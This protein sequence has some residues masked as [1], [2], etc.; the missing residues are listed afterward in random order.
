MG[1]H[2]MI[3]SRK[4]VL[5]GC[6]VLMSVFISCLK[7]SA[8]KAEG[9][10]SSVREEN[11]IGADSA[12]VVDIRAMDY[13]FGMPEEIPS[14]WVTFRMKNMGKE[15]HVAVVNKLVERVNYDRLT[16]TIVKAVSQG[17]VTSFEEIE[18]LWEADMG[19]PGLLSPGRTGETSVFLEPGIYAMSCGVNSPD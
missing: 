16:E 13:A 5:L 2:K 11:G 1:K 9:S 19:G 12:Y 14:G 6:L 8:E 7:N 10:T 4:K 3:T 17:D 18:V 15:E